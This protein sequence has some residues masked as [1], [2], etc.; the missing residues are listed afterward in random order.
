MSILFLFSEIFSETQELIL[1]LNA[2]EI[3]TFW[4]GPRSTLGS[5]AIGR[6]G[7]SCVGR[8][9]IA[10]DA[11]FIRSGEVCMIHAVPE[12]GLTVPFLCWINNCRQHIAL[13]SDCVCDFT[14]NCCKSCNI[15]GLK[16]PLCSKDSTLLCAGMPPGQ[17]GR[18]AHSD[19]RF[20]H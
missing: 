20:A 5:Q 10:E 9:H 13:I 12:P 14:S 18:V 11:Y 4:R 1:L 15:R 8:F 6:G 2:K 7:W 19:F 17:G 3:Q 16:W